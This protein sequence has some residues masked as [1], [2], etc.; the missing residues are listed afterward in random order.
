MEQF[1]KLF[2]SEAVGIRRFFDTLV[3]INDQADYAT[4]L[5]TS[6]RDI[7]RILFRCPTL[8]AEFSKGCASAVQEIKAMLDGKMPPNDES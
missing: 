7:A 3:K 4:F 6:P 1:I 5:G 2:P 8:V